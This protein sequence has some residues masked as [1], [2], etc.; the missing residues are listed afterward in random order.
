M[1]EI[2][3]QAEATVKE[4]FNYI[5]A[6]GNTNYIGEA[7]S[8]LEHSLQAAQLASDSVAERDIIL[9]APPHDI[10]RF[11]PAA[12]KMSEIIDEDGTYVGRARSCWGALSSKTGL[13]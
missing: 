13:Q 8:Q 6:Q 3:K 2:Q 10:G 12:E 7:A 4:V 5:I 9:S 11:I 1:P